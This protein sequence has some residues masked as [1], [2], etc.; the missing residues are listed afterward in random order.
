[1]GFPRQESWSGLPFP[2]PGD[3]PD[4][5]MEPM[6]PEWQVD[7]YHRATREGP[8]PL[9]KRSLAMH[10]GQRPGAFAWPWLM[11]GTFPVLSKD[12]KG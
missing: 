9:K 7:F 1:M 8:T 6:S 3:L 12:F 10:Q 11:A 5:G 2:S 4:P